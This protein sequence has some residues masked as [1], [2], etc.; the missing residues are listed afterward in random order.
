MACSTGLA[1]A[2]GMERVVD[3]IVCMKPVPDLDKIRIRPDTREPVLEGVPFQF[4]DFEKNALEE[5]VRLKEQSGAHVIAL[6]LGP[7]KLRELILEALAMGADEAVLLIDEAFARRGSAATALALAAA[8]RRLGRGDLV[9]MGEGSA[10]NY[11]GQ[12]IS[13][14]AELLG[15]PQVTYVRELSLV[16]A[17]GPL[18][19]V[20]DLEEALEEVE[21]ALPCVVSVTSELNTPRLPP[22]TAILR[23]SRKPVTTWSLPDLDLEASALAAAA[24]LVTRL[25]NLAPAQDRRQVL[26]EGDVESAVDELVATIRREGVL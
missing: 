4:G 11:S 14:L 10:D 19:A 1:N 26:Y 20:R 8:I 9:L 24:A 23:A 2:K 22:L 13:R 5:G 3:V 12:V 21:V 17:G 7:P 15:W 16:G 18:R 6:A 25:S